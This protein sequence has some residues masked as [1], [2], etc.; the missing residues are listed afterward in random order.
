MSNSKNV[1]EHRRR[2]KERVVYYLGGKC[3]LCGYNKCNRS[4]HAHHVEPANKKFSIARKGTTRSWKK[5]RKELDKCVLVCA[6]CHGEIHG[7]QINMSI[8]SEALRRDLLLRN[9]RAET[10]IDNSSLVHVKN[11]CN[12][13][14]VDITYGAKHCLNCNAKI[15]EK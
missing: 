1:S 10:I 11:T 13:C 4:L 14:G 2:T 7:K 6:N 3:I 12:I 15:R 8:L 5:L 9:E